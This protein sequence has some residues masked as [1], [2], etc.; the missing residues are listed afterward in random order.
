MKKQNILT[1]LFILLTVVFL[2]CSNDDIE[3]GLQVIDNDGFYDVLNRESE[4]GYF[5]YIG[6][7]TCMACQEVEPLIERVLMQAQMPLYY[8]QTDLSRE[9]ATGEAEA[10]MLA[11]LEP[12]NIEGIPIIVHLVDGQLA[13]YL[14]GVQDEVT[15]A[16]FLNVEFSVIP[17]ETVVATE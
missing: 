11:L 12:L 4:T 9:D 6:R 17:E 3:P 1:C 2:G 13:S 10:R 7:P 15:I 14:I 5:V 8:F 16:T